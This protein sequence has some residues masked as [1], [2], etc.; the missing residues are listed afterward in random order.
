MGRL[1][2]FENGGCE[3]NFFIGVGSRYT[4]GMN[5]PWRTF[6]RPGT[7]F[8]EC[9]RGRGTILLSGRKIVPVQGTGKKKK[10]DRAHSQLAVFV[11][12]ARSVFGK[13]CDKQL[14]HIVR[15]ISCYILL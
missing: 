3:H 10:I 4:A 14:T 9:R 12:T 8:V 13:K 6:C 5:K 15:V 11:K 1:C 7:I 2:W